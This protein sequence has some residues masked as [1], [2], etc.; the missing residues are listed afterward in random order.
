MAHFITMRREACKK[1][2]F[3]Y[4]KNKPAVMFYCIPNMHCHRAHHCQQP[5][6]Q[7]EIIWIVRYPMISQDIVKLMLYHRIRIL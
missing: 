2:Q 5:R 1:L 6:N 7:L 3:S 4:V